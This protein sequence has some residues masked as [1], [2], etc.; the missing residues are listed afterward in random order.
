MSLPATSRPPYPDQRRHLGKYLGK[1][2]ASIPETMKG[3][4]QLHHAGS[5]DGALSAKT[6]EL[7]ALAVAV[8]SHCDGCVAFHTH[9]ALKAGAS[10]EEIMEAVEQFREERGG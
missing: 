7:I 10:D 9:D 8:T 1:L 6:K 2:R 5:S 3:F 4:A